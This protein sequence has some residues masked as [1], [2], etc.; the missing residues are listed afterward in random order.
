MEFLTASEQHLFRRAQVRQVL[1]YLRDADRSRYCSE[2]S[3]LL[4]D[5]R[6]RIHIKDLILA[7]LVSVDDPDDDEWAVLEPWL[8][9]QLAAFADDQRKRESL[10]LLYGNTSLLHPLGFILLTDVD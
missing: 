8:N 2:L 6:V 10:L 1:A 3:A 5:S 7:T 9:L 4:A